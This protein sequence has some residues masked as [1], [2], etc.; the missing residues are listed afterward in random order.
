MLCGAPLLT[1]FDPSKRIVVHCDASP[2]GLGVVLSHVMEDGSERPVTFS[3][4]TLSVAERNYAH[5]EK[6]G[7]AL[8]YAVKKFHQFLF[9]KKFVMYTDHK[10]LL[11]LFSER[12]ELPVRAAARVLRWA[13]LLS[14]YDYTLQ[15]RPGSSNANADAL[16]RLPLDA[17]SGDISQ[18]VVSVSMMELANS[19]VSEHDVRLATR[20][21]PILGVVLNQIL[22]GWSNEE[23][24]SEVSKHY[25]TRS[26]EL[27]T[28]GGC[29]M[30]GGRVVIPVS[31]RKKVLAE[32]HAVHPGMSRMKS[33]ARSYLWWPGVDKD[34]EEMVRQCENCQKNQKN[35]IGA[36][37]HSWE[38][39]RSPWERIHVDH[40][41]PVNGK[42]FLVVVD[43]FSK[44]IEVEVVGSTNAE[45]TT[46]VLR[47]MFATH[48]IP[49]VLVS[50][51]GPGFASD[52]FN[53]FLKRNGVKHLYS[54]PYHPSSN[55]QAERTVRTFKESLKSMKEGNID[56][57][58]CRFLFTYRITP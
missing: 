58:L 41:G 18:K 56:T 25:Q 36:P 42:M 7:L 40:A 55:S 50:D 27:T 23:H 35:P 6:E 16:S 47:K 43:S 22:E 4:R 49:R 5:I 32:L 53:V 45:S 14:A 48:G 12:C 57:K 9:G 3:S 54:A 13:L 39:P 29:I 21:D 37:V 11:G 10:P 24:S 20:T 44:W 17:N 2:Y 46:A 26:S 30:W 15:H 31:L 1:H 28:E 33:L 38:Y 8:V 51:N 34:I 52:E 19:P